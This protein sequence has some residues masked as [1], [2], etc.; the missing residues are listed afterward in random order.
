MTPPLTQTSQNRCEFLGLIPLITAH[1]K[2]EAKKDCPPNC[3]TDTTPPTPPRPHH[4]IYDTW[5]GGCV[6]DRSHHGQEGGKSPVSPPTMMLTK[7]KQTQHPFP[8]KQKNEIFQ[9]DIISL[10]WK[11]ACPFCKKLN[12]H[13]YFKVYHRCSEEA[14]KNKLH[15]GV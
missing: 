11:R 1:A 12:I 3:C 14:L 9:C 4:E 10:Y 15:K 5:V 8:R 2:T 13:I 7:T 6:I